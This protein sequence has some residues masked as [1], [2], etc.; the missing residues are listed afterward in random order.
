MNSRPPSIR[1]IIKFHRIRSERWFIIH[2]VLIFF[3]FFCRPIFGTWNV[4]K[5]WCTF[6]LIPPAYSILITYFHQRITSRELHAGKCLWYT[7]RIKRIKR[8]SNVKPCSRWILQLQY[9][10][11]KKLHPLFTITLTTVD[12]IHQS[13][14]FPRFSRDEKFSPAYILFVQR[15]SMARMKRSKIC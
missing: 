12:G 10:P 3:F 8:G 5:W 2:H 11:R 9:N 4:R 14:A 13:T 1:Y 6:H 15:T 7:N